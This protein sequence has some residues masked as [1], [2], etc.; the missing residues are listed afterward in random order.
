MQEEAARGSMRFAK[1]GTRMIRIGR[2]I[3][4]AVLA[5][6]APGQ[7]PPVSPSEAETPRAPPWG[8]SMP[9]I[10]Q[11]AE[12]P[13]LISTNTP[14]A[15]GSRTIQFPSI[16]CAGFGRSRSL[17]SGT[18]E[19]WQDLSRAATKPAS[20]LEADMAISFGV[21]DVEALQ[22]KTSSRSAHARSHCR[23]D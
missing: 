23:S 22:K 20:A 21:P 13:V 15:T 11:S 4:L 9:A 14:A 19:L 5:S 10:E 3:L 1:T 17:G 8:V 16:R 2:V 6:A 12:T 7:T 18:C